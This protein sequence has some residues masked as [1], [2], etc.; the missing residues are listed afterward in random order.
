M[1]LGK[2]I[3]CVIP[4]RLSSSRFPRKPLAM[5]KDR[6]MVLRVADV[7]S[8]SKYIDNV[9]IATED[10]EIVDLC[11]K[12]NYESR[13]TRKHYTCTHRV[14]EVSQD[15][16]SDFILN[17]QGDEPL[18]RSDWLDQVIKFGVRH[19]CDMV[20]PMRQLEQSD[21]QDEDV[22][23]MICNNGKITNMMRSCELV[24]DNI[25]VQLGFYL[26]KTSVIRDFPNCD[27]GIVQYWKGLDT[28]GFIGKYDVTP[29]DLE[30]GK[31][32]SVDRP[33]HIQ[34]VESKL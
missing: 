2:K 11:K 27:M 20:Q 25:V 14:A 26:Y 34:E 16:E 32:R 19:Q 3:T 17:Y 22:V 21:L 23:K 29:Y 30:C 18:I 9:I 8:R 31:I 7:A 33:S 12:N 24:C 13:L 28:I 4:A 6:E 5:I 15:V 1:Y 10:Q